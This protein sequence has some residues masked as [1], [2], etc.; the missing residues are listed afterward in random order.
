MR[1]PDG[2]MNIP[3]FKQ[4]RAFQLDPR[5]LACELDSTMAETK[6]TPAERA[7]W[8]AAA[9]DLTA[10]GRID[11]APL[12]AIAT[13]PETV[14]VLQD[15]V[16]EA[17]RRACVPRLLAAFYRNGGTVPAEL[18]S[19]LRQTTLAILTQLLPPARPETE[20]RDNV[21]PTPE[22]TPAPF[23]SI[24]DQSTWLLGATRRTADHASRVSEACGNVLE[25]AAMAFFGINT[26]ADVSNHLKQS[27]EDISQQ[28]A[29]TAEASVEASA[30]ADRAS[31]EISELTDAATRIGSVT[32]LIRTIAGQTNLLALNATIEAARAGQAGKGFAVVAGEV[33]ALAKQTADATQQ[34]ETM[35]NQIRIAV[36][37]AAERVQGIQRATAEVRQLTADGAHAVESQR[38][39]ATEISVASADAAQAVQQMQ[40]G[41]ERVASDCFALSTSIEE[42]SSGAEI[43]SAKAEM[44]NASA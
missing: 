42:L 20:L 11:V 34:I 19:A 18:R 16:L 38:V 39:S 37:A 13:S 24:A 26:N 14:M 10:T 35:V 6:T 7:A 15:C 4:P 40:D 12:H 28:L 25:S 27:I 21:A 43:M 8:R 3:I 23:V 33:K 17:M 30:S 9:L 41:I 32:N 1:R 31:T 36:A 5:A 44:L 29:R 22:Q 2:S